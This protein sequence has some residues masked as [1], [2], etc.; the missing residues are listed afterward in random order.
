MQRRLLIVALCALPLSLTGLMAEDGHGGGKDGD[1]NRVRAK[2]SGPAISGE[3]PS[4]SAVSSS[5]D[6]QNSFRV[7]VEDVNLPDGARL[8]VNLMHEGNRMRVGELTIMGGSGELDLHARN[9]DQVPQAQQGDVVH[10][11]QGQMSIL[12]GVFF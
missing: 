11:S 8:T 12:A 7:E 2:L 3:T 1:H 10:V 4:G 6:G 5:H 9:G